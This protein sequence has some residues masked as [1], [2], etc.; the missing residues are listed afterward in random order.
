MECRCA[1]LILWFSRLDYMQLTVGT[2]MASLSAPASWG[3]LPDLG[4]VS[5]GNR[6]KCQA[7]LFRLFHQDSKFS[8]PHHT[9]S[10]HTDF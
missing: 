3:T 8:D 1:C 7:S 6:M 2:W 9:D 10:L 5:R 4:N